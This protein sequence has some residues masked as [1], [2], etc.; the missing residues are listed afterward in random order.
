MREEPLDQPNSRAI[1]QWFADFPMVSERIDNSSEA[2]AI[3]VADGPDNGGSRCGGSV[4][5]GIGIL[6]RHHHA[7]RTTAERF[8]TE[9]RVLWRFVRDPKFRFRNRQPG[10]HRST[11]GVDAE[12]FTSS[13]GRLVEQDCPCSVSNREHGGYSRLLI[14][15]V[16]RLL[17]HKTSELWP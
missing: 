13:E 15:G 7:H 9:V 8:R 16:V 6:H 2:P 3:L 10:D 17:A 1:G 4:A 12:Q 11:L 5:G 14:T